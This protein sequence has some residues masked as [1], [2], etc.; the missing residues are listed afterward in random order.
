MAFTKQVSIA[1]ASALGIAVTM[2]L[3]IPAFSDSSLSNVAKETA[4]PI[5]VVLFGCVQG[6]H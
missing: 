4:P 2:P 1:I 3:T 6:I 5:S